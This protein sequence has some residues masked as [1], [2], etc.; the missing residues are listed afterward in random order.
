[1]R[2]GRI[3]SE[4]SCSA[5]VVVAAAAADSGVFSVLLGFVGPELKRSSQ[6]GSR[7]ACFVVVGV[8]LPSE[9]EASA[10]VTDFVYVREACDFRGVGE[11]DL[12][13]RS[14]NIYIC[15]WMAVVSLMP[16]RIRR[17]IVVW[18]LRLCAQ[19]KLS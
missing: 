12:A 19:M 18:C 3:D 10:P 13:I 5:D 16:V 15:Y 8:L 4:L 9:L 1:M 17:A 14:V 7:R 6:L 2:P 11:S